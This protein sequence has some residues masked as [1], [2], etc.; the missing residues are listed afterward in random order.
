M[1]AKSLQKDRVTVRMI[2]K[3]KNVP[4]RLI[5][6]PLINNRFQKITCAFLKH[7]VSDIEHIQLLF[8]KVNLDEYSV[9]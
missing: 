2:M 6:P 9:C 3:A 7:K 1:N 8:K 4:V 5:K